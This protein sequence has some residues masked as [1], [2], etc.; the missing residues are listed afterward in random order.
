[1]KKKGFKPKVAQMDQVKLDFADMDEDPNIKEA[2]EEL[3]RKGQEI[4][5]LDLRKR[6]P[7][8]NIDQ[9]LFKRPRTEKQS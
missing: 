4:H 8:I 7:E 1:M 2:V 6:K 5:K 3:R 9:E